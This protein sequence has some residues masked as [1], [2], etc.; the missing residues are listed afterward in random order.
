MTRPSRTDALIAV[1]LIGAALLEQALTERLDALD[2]LKVAGCAALAWRR[3]APVPVCLGAI[4]LL[5]AGEPLAPGAT[6][7]FGVIV[8][9]AFAVFTLAASAERRRVLP[10]LL[11]AGALTI[12]LSVLAGLNDQT[13]D[14]S[15]LGM[16]VPSVLFGALVVWAP[17]IVVGRSVRRQGEL[18][19]QLGERAAELEGERDRHAA[20]AAAEA[21]G[22]AAEDLHGIVAAGVRDMLTEVATARRDA[23][24][25]PPSAVAAVARAEERGRAALTLM[26]E[27]LGVLRRGDEALALAPVPSLDRLDVL[28]GQVAADG[29]A[30]RLHTEGTPRRL[31]PGL[32][33]AAYRVVQDVLCSADPGRADVLVRWAP[34]AV[35]L[36]VAVDG[37]AL[38][39]AR[40]LGA[41]RERVA[42]FGG[43]LEAG[44]RPRGGSAVRADL[45]ARSAT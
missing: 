35:R 4:V 8:P 7:A 22:R 36:E 30:V 27:V 12:A 25:D 2:L 31:P 39:D 11:V 14:A 40:G 32:D 19:R 23:V 5:A 24:A 17:A 45:P 1:G 28:A 13:E 20:T 21:R 16:I 9:I 33:A 15:S 38:A 3:V 44:R 18:R 6:D 10:A 34:R 41:T 37:P 43:T 29:L 26:R 42:L